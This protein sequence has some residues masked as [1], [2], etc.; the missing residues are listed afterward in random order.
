MKKLIPGA[1]ATLI[2]FACGP[3]E[4]ISRETFEQVNNANEVKRLT[5]VEILEEAMVWGDSISSEAQSQL[6][7][8]LQKAISEKGIDGAVE[9]C[10]V[11]ALPILDEVSKKYDVDIRRVS[12]RNRNPASLPN[13]EEKPLLDA[14]EYTAENG[15]ESDPNIQKIENG[16]VY[17]YTK[18]IVIPGGLCLSCHGEPGKEIDEKTIQKLKELYP[19]DQAQGHK[20]GDLR[21]I[22]AVRIP[23]REVVKRL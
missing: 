3:Q 23:K 22:W 13:E 19:T 1:F 18:A 11:Q 12:N 20:V 4:R 15:G 6:L 2:L 21:G 10:H 16:E 5:E 14:Y 17:L 7:S 9:F 8:N